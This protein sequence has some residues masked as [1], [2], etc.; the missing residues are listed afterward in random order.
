MFLVND[1]KQVAF[2]GN[3]LLRCALDPTPVLGLNNTAGVVWGAGNSVQN[4]TLPWLCV[5]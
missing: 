4:S 1:A 3:T 2:T 5:K